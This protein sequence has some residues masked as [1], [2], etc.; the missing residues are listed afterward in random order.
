MTLFVHT[1]PAPTP[2]QAEH[3]AAPGIPVVE[4]EVAVVEVAHDQLS[5]VRLASGE[6]VARQALVVMPR[7]VARADV[8][9][10]LG[11]E[12]PEQMMN[13]HQIGRYIAVD[14]MGATSVPGVWAAGNVTNLTSGVINAAAGG[15]ECRRGQRRPYY[16]G[17][18]GR[19]GGRSRSVR[20]R[21]SWLSDE[22]GPYDRGRRSEVVRTI[23][24]DHHRRRNLASAFR[25][26]PFDL[27][28]AQFLQSPVDFPPPPRKLWR[29]STCV[30]ARG[31]AAGS[32]GTIGRW[33]WT[34]VPRS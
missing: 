6:R 19:G 33:A 1:G 7:F 3:R 4:G 24:D 34:A 32:S 21:A 15:D 10:S 26:A 29:P 8:L 30:L 31:S 16:R 18:R 12:T 9:T 2:E 13:A 17:H 11:V 22:R 27:V 23:W 28:S 25:R 14:P 20:T 5:G